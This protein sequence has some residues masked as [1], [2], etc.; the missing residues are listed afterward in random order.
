MVTRGGQ[1][2]HWKGIKIFSGGGGGGGVGRGLKVLG[3][4]L[5]IHVIQITNLS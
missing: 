3:L 1:L 4:N 2:P 5:I